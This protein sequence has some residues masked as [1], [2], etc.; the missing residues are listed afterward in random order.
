MH[1]LITK[2]INFFTDF[3]NLKNLFRKVL[4]LSLQGCFTYPTNIASVNLVMGCS[5]ARAGVRIVG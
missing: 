5:I 3:K 4:A 2:K 1:K